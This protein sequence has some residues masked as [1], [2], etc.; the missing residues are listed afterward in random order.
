MV[1]TQPSL[2]SSGIAPEVFLREK[3]KAKN[4][5]P[6]GLGF[7]VWPFSLKPFSSHVQV[8]SC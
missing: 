2:A 5:L 1:S 3:R 7:R 4:S 6:A 8:L